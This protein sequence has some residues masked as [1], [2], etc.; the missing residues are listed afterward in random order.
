MANIEKCLIKMLSAM[1]NEHRKISGGTCE[2]ELADVS[3]FA[4]FMFP[5]RSKPAHFGGLIDRLFYNSPLTFGDEIQNGLHFRNY[6]YFRFYPF[7]SL[8]GV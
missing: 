6:L 1:E 7:H 4:K 5:N 2:L 3:T 8:R